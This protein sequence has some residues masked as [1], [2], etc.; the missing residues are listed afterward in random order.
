M[1]NRLAVLLCLVPA[2][3]YAQ[4]PRSV[5]AHGVMDLAVASDSNAG[6]SSMRVDS[7]QQTASRLGILGQED[8]GGGLSASLMLE[9]HIESDTGAPSFAGRILGSQAWVGLSS[10]VGTVR[11]G[12]MFTP[13]FGAIATN[14]PFGTRGPGESTHVF[15]DAG[16]RM[17][18]AVK[19]SLPSRL[20][21]FYGDIAWAAGESAAYS[22][23]NRQVS[24]DVGY[25][26]GIFNLQLAHHD[27]NDALGTTLARSTMIGGNVD[28]GPVRG[29]LAAARSSNDMTL[30]TRD[31]LVGVSVPF[32]LNVLSAD[33]VRKTDRN[34]VN[35]GARQVAAGYYHWLSKRTNLYLVSSRLRNGSTA[36][37]QTTLPGGSRRVIAAGIRHQF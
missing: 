28:L 26:A 29:W 17:D 31:L 34:N 9:S 35:G 16:M 30:N 8:L 23:A 5:A 6:K 11:A 2:W 33:Y 24:L 7:G 19:Y 37:Y 12:R 36:N 25:K 32:G 4:Q 13:Y 20:N 3:A 14:D 21:G 10:P 1:Q 15:Y 18:H 27:A 22:G